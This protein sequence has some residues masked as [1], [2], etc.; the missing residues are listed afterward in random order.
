[1]MQL[2]DN[3]S[4]TTYLDNVDTCNIIKSTNTKHREIYKKICCIALKFGLK[5]HDNDILAARA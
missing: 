1:M 2:R 4:D 5:L 3:D